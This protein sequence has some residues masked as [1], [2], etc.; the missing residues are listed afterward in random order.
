M[1]YEEEFVTDLSRSVE[2]RYTSHWNL[3][4]YPAIA[5]P[6]KT[7]VDASLDTITKSSDWIP[8]CVEEEEMYKNCKL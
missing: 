7:S 8:L 1:L 5:F 6:V 3:V 2:N 4:D